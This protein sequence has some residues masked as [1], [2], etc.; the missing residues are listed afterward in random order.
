[1]VKKIHR[2]LAEACVQ[3]LELI[4]NYGKVPDRTVAR[5]L[6]THPKWGSRDRAFVAETVYEVV[7]WRRRLAFLAGSE[8]TSA[9]AG[10]QWMLN[11]YPRPDWAEWPGIPQHVWEERAASLNSAPR[12]IRESLSDELDELGERELGPQ[13]DAELPA[14]NRPAPVFLRVNSLRSTLPA[15]KEELAKHGYT[16]TEVPGVPLA[17]CLDGGRT[18]PARLKDSGRFEIQD[19]G[20]QQIAPFLQAEPGQRVVDACAGAGGK[21]LHL[22]ALMEG[23]GQLF[24]LDVEE[25]KLVRLKSRAR[26][27]GLTVR[28]SVITPEILA[29]LHSSADRVLIDAPC[30]GSGTLRRQPDLKFRI[31]A[32]AVKRIQAVQRD[33]L[34]KFSALVRPGGR[35]VYATCSLFPGENE[36]QAAW[37]SAQR[38]DFIFEEER[39]ISPASTGWDGFYMARWTRQ[40]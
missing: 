19:A 23:R 26:R 36:E 13:W 29:K 7:R 4:F 14:L 2:H 3:T 6:A 16:A 9:L 21:T 5:V 10:V 34:M 15:A 39:R 37:F 24:A 40:E 28:A 27:A 1:V 22:G 32:G 33:L 11:G 12:T 20:S 38:D 18:I 17:L 30:S 35:M 8:E 31:T 25:A